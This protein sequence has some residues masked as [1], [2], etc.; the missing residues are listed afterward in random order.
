[1]TPAADYWRHLLAEWAIP[2]EIRA[3]APEFPYTMD[4]DLFRPRPTPEGTSLATDRARHALETVPT[5]DRTLLDVG[6]GGGAAT[7]ALADL[8]VHATGVDQSEAMLDLFTEEAAARDLPSTTVCG[9]WPDV[10]DTVGTVGVV[11]CHHV[12]Y[13]VAD[14]A[15]FVLALSRAAR[16]RVVMEL[17]TAH[18]QTSNAPLWDQFWH[19]DRPSGP[20]AQNA[21]DVLVEAGIDATLETGSAGSLRAEASVKAR[22]VTAA[23]MLCLGPDR[24]PEVEAAIRQLPPRSNERAIIWW[25]VS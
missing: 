13:N 20:S 4:P 8:A 18:P 7:M 5:S 12:A 15:P 10:E 19:L 11:V 17:T 22:A 3:A 2:A 24:V 14:L 21:L 6:C 16:A 9:S 25:D 23:R 1:M